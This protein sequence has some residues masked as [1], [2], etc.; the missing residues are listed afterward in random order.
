[1][2]FWPAF[3][4]AAEAHPT[5]GF[6]F[7]DARGAETFITYAALAEHSAHLGGALRA[8][9]LRPLEEQ[10]IYPCE[11]MDRLMIATTGLG[12]EYSFPHSPLLH[13]VGPCMPRTCVH[14]RE[15]MLAC[16]APIR[17]TNR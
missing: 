12:F 11:T 2:S 16:T 13:M 10:D 7:L 3:C 15:A 5:R 9:G 1:M 8:R 17:W 14:I 4:D 6:W